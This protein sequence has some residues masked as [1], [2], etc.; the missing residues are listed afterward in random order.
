MEREPIIAIGLLT[1]TH[2][3]MLGDSLKHVFPVADD[4]AFD[5]L[6]KAL[7]EMDRGQH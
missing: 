1:N 6:L 7:D 3:R 4:N 2:M 5:D